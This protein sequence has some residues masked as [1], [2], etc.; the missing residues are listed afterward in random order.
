MTL[1][2][3]ALLFGIAVMV[4]LVRSFAAD[5]GI[6]FSRFEGHEKI[7]KILKLLISV[8]TA[9]YIVIFVIVLIKTIMA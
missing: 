2:I 3:L 9:A 4:L 5:G 1:I 7:C 8:E 6:G